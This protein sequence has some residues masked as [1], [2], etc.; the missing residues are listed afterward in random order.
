MIN[1]S[2]RLRIATTDDSERVAALH[3]TSWRSAY[4]GMLPDSYLDQA[5]EA[6]RL[7]LWQA[8]LGQA[9]TQRQY[10]A[11]AE[12]GQQLIGFV[13]VLLDEEPAWGA[14]LDNLHVDPA[15]KRRGIGRI[16]F[17]QAA[18]WVLEQEPSWPLHLLV[19]EANQPARRFYEQYLG[20][21]VEQM[22]KAMPGDVA[23][24]VVRYS[25]NDLG[26]LVTALRQSGDQER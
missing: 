3:T 16:L 23:L 12:Q 15:Q 5:I 1:Q 9:T 21:V 24:P 22:I 18:V 7:Q 8:R 4:R 13:C 11:L 20:G 25:W 6:E 19:F 2:I 14:Y 17:A 26:A 10:V